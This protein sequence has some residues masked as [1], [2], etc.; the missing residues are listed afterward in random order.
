MSETN[1][2]RTARLKR[3]AA[4]ADLYQL[5]HALARARQ[6]LAVAQRRG[7]VESIQALEREIEVVSNERAG[8]AVERQRQREV[9][10]RLRASLV[11]ADEDEFTHMRGALPI[12]L[13]PVR[14]ETHFRKQQDQITELLIRIYPDDIHVESHEPELTDNEV[15]AGRR[16]WL[17]I[18]RAVGDQ[19]RQSLAWRTLAGSV[20]EERA[21]WVKEV[22]APLNEPPSLEAPLAADEAL[23][24]MPEFPDPAR[25]EGDWT[26]APK[27]RALPDR[28][29]ALGF[30][31]GERLFQVTGNVI[32]DELAVA[33][34]PTAE[35]A[36]DENLFIDDDSRWTIDFAE[37][38]RAGMGIRVQATDE[39]GLSEGL[40]LLLVLGVK[41]SASAAE[42]AEM[43]T[44]LLQTHSFGEGLAFLRRGVPTNNTEQERSDWRERNLPALDEKAPDAAVIAPGD[45]TNGG[46]W[47]GALGLDEEQTLR[48]F[49]SISGAAEQADKDARAMNAAL[50]PATWGYILEHML[51]EDIRPHIATVRHHALN[52]LRA[53]GNF[54]SVRVGAQP[55]GLIIQTDLDQY[56]LSQTEQIERQLL[57]LLQRLRTEFWL[58]AT[59]RVPRVGRTGDPE[60]DLV[61]ILG[62]EAVSASYVARPAL[63]SELLANLWNLFNDGTFT[64]WWNRHQEIA[65]EAPNKLGI[66]LDGR[67]QHLAYFEQ[68]S[69]IIQTLVQAGVTEP[70]QKLDPNYIDWL[71]THGYSRIQQERFPADPPDA[72]LYLLLR[73][74]AL[75]ETA[76]QSVVTWLEAQP[77]IAIQRL[78]PELVDMRP[79][80]APAAGEAEIVTTQTPLDMTLGRVLTTP[81]PGVTD[82]RAVG[83]YLSD[84]R[85]S[86]DPDLAPFVEFWSALAHLK[87]LPV[88]RLELLMRETLDLS[89]HRLDAW[90][91]SFSHRLLDRRRANE[92]SATGLYVGGYGWVE[93]LKP[94]QTERSDGYVHTPSN[95]HAALAAVLRSAYLSHRQSADTG[96]FAIDLSSERVRLA[97]WLL[98]GVRAG[99]PLGALLGYRLER[100]LHE[101]HSGLELDVFIYALRRRAPLVAGKLE[102]TLEPFA[103]VAAGNVVDGHKLVRHW[104]KGELSFTDTDLPNPGTPEHTAVISELEGL[105]ALIDAV[106]DALLAESVFQLGNSA[107]VGATV[108][109]MAGGEI[110][111]PELEFARTP[112]R[113]LGLIHRLVVARSPEPADATTWTT[114]SNQVRAVADP[115]LNRW[116]AEVLGEATSYRYQVRYLASD[117]ELL[118]MEPVQSLAD[119]PLS[120]LDAVFLADGEDP[121]TA[122]ELLALMRHQ[123]HLN[124]PLTVP[125]DARVELQLEITGEASLFPA[126]LETARALRHVIQ[127]AHP[128]DGTDLTPLG[129]KSEPGIDLD[130]FET[131]VDGLVARFVQ[132]EANLQVFLANAAT[133]SL[134]NGRSTLLGLFAFGLRNTIPE[135]AT[136][137]DERTRSTLVIQ[138]EAVAQA[139]SSRR[140]ELDEALSEF[141]AATTDR[142][143]RIAHA[144]RLAHA[145]LGGSLPVLPQFV[146]AT[147]LELAQ[148]LLDQA[149]L[150]GGDAQAV[151]TWLKQMARV[152][153]RVADINDVLLY[154][155]ALTQAKPYPLQIAQLPFRA[156][157]LWAAL[158]GIVD[159]E[160]DANRLSLLFVAPET[161]DPTRPL[162]GFV[163]DEW[164]ET[165]PDTTTTTATAIHYDQPG[166]RAANALLLAVAPE[167][168]VPWTLATL[169]KIVLDTIEMAKLRAVD[170]DDLRG[171]GQYL[172][173]LL[174]ASNYGGDTVD[175]PLE[176]LLGTQDLAVGES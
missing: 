123:A 79:G 43:A 53:G 99:L 155:A 8:R 153:D 136:G 109:A 141:D 67:M 100:A 161:F 46:R 124:R 45:A 41:G 151:G 154:R 47:A 16:Y 83:A 168:E 119:L 4:V 60:R 6:Q 171:L 38:E 72:L 129:E 10:E 56:P 106:G 97:D 21:A 74:A 116:A 149:T 15:E 24:E 42:G 70:D 51:G 93:D 19:T 101:Q 65:Q 127:H 18:W 131:R 90:L 102:T 48:A 140:R 164:S 137:D 158:P 152:R 69:E 103:A 170:G 173:A 138:A 57:Q 82:G 71:L 163:I 167:A 150:Q 64:D 157:S 66:A 77:D 88:Q 135:P 35:R 134:D 130:E 115:V 75:L 96:A 176:R 81:I 132:L 11:A 32:P 73:Q 175:M 17:E 126:L 36:E 121:E 166:A 118:L 28:W 133:A 84:R 108:D 105:E 80:K 117:S 86:E 5:N 55:Y 13:L 62:Q 89:S 111:P 20:G 85:Q 12:L 174:F 113:G 63:G 139:V 27:A 110:P 165:I 68:F 104:Q 9:I 58:P 26:R 31:D 148:S 159:P 92:T 112:R 54:A 23:P 49:A 120:T 2:L 33:P 3:D 114:D 40:D 1:P 142:G 22:T 94:R 44:Q 59:R 50:W 87:D 122:V 95:E 125:I 25:K 30:R 107:R 37:A 147:G 146:A 76:R 34:D 145:I 61:E 98:E 39:R 162:S 14:L 144:R 128:L 78:E 160:N 172:P 29:L 7:E 156:G 169:Q 52:W 143:Q 91:S